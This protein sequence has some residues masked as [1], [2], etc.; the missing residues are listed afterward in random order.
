MT[1]TRTE[2]LV[3]LH[4]FSI[5]DY[6]LK[7]PYSDTA[8]QKFKKVQAKKLVKSNKSKKN[9][10][11]REIAYLAVLNFFLVQKL[12]FGHFWNSKKW[13]LA[14]KK[15]K[16]FVKLIYF[17]FLA[18]CVAAQKLDV[19]WFWKPLGHFIHHDDHHICKRKTIE[20]LF[21][22]PSWGQNAGHQPWK[23]GDHESWPCCWYTH[24]S[25]LFSKSSKNNFRKRK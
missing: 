20:W 11:F 23:I 1:E 7:V 6:F 13:N 19:M 9:F 4:F 24:N 16:K 10:F 17:Q 21:W 14:K 15:K 5:F 3:F 25:K 18:H 12:I 22:D 2:K 8:S